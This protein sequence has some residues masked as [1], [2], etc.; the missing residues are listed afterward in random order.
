MNRESSSRTTAAPAA[1]VLLLCAALSGC[2]RGDVEVY[3]VPK[4]SAPGPQPHAPGMPP[5]HPTMGA[6]ARPGIQYQ[7]PDGWQEGLPSSMRAASFKVTS[8]DASADVAVIPLPPGGS[9][10]DLVNMWRSEVQLPPTTA[11]G[12]ASESS[13]VPVGDASGTFY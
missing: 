8:G 1:C 4:E 6:T 13:K 10:L 3:S 9:D 7:L 5:N 11:Q 12:A 2:G